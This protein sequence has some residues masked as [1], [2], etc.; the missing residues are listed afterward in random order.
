MYFF[1]SI[2]CDSEKLRIV[3]TVQD[4]SFSVVFPLQVC[5]DCRAVVHKKETKSFVLFE[6]C[7]RDCIVYLVLF[8]KR[9]RVFGY[10]RK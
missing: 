8:K 3:M 1:N 9:I 6:V 7:V 2:P 4:F 10:T 5:V